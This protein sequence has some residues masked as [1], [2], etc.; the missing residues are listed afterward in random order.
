MEYNKLIVVIFPL[1][2]GCC[3]SWIMKNEDTGFEPATFNRH[4]VSEKTL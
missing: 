3:I 1:L 4:G 2:A